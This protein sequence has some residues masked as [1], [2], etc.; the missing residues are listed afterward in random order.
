MLHGDKDEMTTT[1]TSSSRPCPAEGGWLGVNIDD[2]NPQLGD[3]FGVEDGD[4]VLV[5][6]VVEDGPA[7]KAGL[8]AGDVIVKV[9]GDEVEDTGDLHETLA[10]TEADQKVKIEYLRKGKEQER[11]GHPGRRCPRATLPDAALLR[12]RRRIPAGPRR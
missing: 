3:Y 10:G 4:G 7:A 2:L 9:G 8:K 5:T 6:A 11:R 12:R 1:A